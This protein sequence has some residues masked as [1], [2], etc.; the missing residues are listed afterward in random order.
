M[1]IYKSITHILVIILV[2][3]NFNSC[4]EENT[5]QSDPFVV[6]FESLSAN[7]V[8]IETDQTIALVYSET[9]IESGT[10][11][12]Q[13]NSENATYGIDFTTI[14]EPIGSTITLP[15]SAGEIKN[16]IVFNKLNPFLDETSRIEFKITSIN[17]QNSNIQGYTN[18]LLNASASL[19]GSMEP[20]VSGPNEG[21]QVFI[22]LSSKASILIQRDSWDLGFYCGDDFRVGINGSIYMAAAQLNVT[23]IDAVTQNSVSSLQSQ[24]AIGTFNPANA[25][26][27][28][29]PSGSILE[30]AIAEISDNDS[31]NKVY[32]I[33]LGYEVGTATPAAGSVAIAGNHRGWKKI[34]I[35]KEGENYKLQYANLNDT[36]H[37]EVILNKNTKFNFTF[38]SFN[39]NNVVSVEPEKDR[40]DISFTV[41]TNIIEGAGS[42]GY[43]DFVTHNRKGG[44]KAYMVETAEFK[45]DDFNLNNVNENLLSEDQRLIGDKWRDV[46]TGSPYNNRFF[47]IKDPNNNLYKIKFLALTNENGV[48]GYPKFEYKLLQ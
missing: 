40:W 8:T 36:T 43:S 9:S 15:I 7:L 32:L 2:V 45:Y 24:V 5:L 1:K 35:L 39:T 3:F 47:V 13:I 30:T 16:A 44:A 17:Y 37:Q 46:F 27:I 26:Y 6:A 18:F 12:I 4:S 19:G 38:F 34:R 23:D 20:E 31:D 14:P 10:V 21:N 22:D 33:N 42:Y 48:R 28:D 29:A 25:A 11:N 41:F